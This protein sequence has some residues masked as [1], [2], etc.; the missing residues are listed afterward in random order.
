MH[1]ALRRTVQAP[2]DVDFGASLT[3]HQHRGEMLVIDQGTE[4]AV[5]WSLH[6]ACSPFRG[7]KKRLWMQNVS[8]K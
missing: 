1:R 6:Q 4:F 3:I 2:W 8:V 5:E 7:W